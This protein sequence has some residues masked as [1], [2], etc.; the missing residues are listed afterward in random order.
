[1]NFFPQGISDLI[2][3]E[4][5]IHK[6]ERGY[7]FETFKHDFFKKSLGFEVN[8]IQDNESQST[9]GVLRGLH[10][11]IPPF[12]QTKLV[13]VIQGKVLDVVV[14]IRRNSKTFGQHIAVE[15]SSE[16]KF[17]LYIPPGFAHGYVVLSESAIFAYKVDSFY[18]SSHDRGIAYNDPK[19]DIDWK[20]PISELKLSEKDKKHPNLIDSIDLFE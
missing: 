9:K 8:F 3:I 20:L 6:D 4:P 1:M 15:L 5:T 12:E 16:N 13:R 2:L 17:Q 14:D 7:F 19:L 18:S 10:Y 11:Q